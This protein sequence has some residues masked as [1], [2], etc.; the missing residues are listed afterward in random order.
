MLKIHDLMRAGSVKRFHIVNT[1]RI[2]SLADHQYGVAVLAGEL[3]KRLGLNVAAQAR[4]VASA[5]VHDAGEARSGDIPTPAKKKLR[6]AFGEKFDEL[7]AEYDVLM[8]MHDQDKLI[9]KCADYLESMI[10]LQEH[11]VGRHAETVLE[12]IIKNAFE[13]FDNCDA[14]GTAAYTIWY[15]I[16]RAEY[17]I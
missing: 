5:I 4:V 11:T 12:D 9:I 3:S 7:L 2:Q 10:F 1:T 15:D 17:E 6:R 16:L 13:F 14:V 8:T